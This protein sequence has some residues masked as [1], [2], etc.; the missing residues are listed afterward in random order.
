MRHHGEVA[1]LR[2]WARRLGL[3][4]ASPVRP[5]WASENLLHRQQVAEAKIQRL[6]ICLVGRAG[7]QVLHL[8]L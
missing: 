2:R 5:S 3:I 4:N 7:A 1:E 6:R 8:T